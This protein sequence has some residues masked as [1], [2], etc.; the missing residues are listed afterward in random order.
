MG[1]CED[2]WI[3]CVCGLSLVD[4]VMEDRENYLKS[5]IWYSVIWCVCI[6]G[7]V[8]FLVFESIDI[9]LVE[10]SVSRCKDV[11]GVW[12]VFNEFIILLVY[13]IFGLEMRFEDGWEVVKF[14]FCMSFRCDFYEYSSLGIYF[15]FFNVL[16]NCFCVFVLFFIM[17][18]CCRNLLL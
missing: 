18:K 6:V 5:C 11:Y 4:E 14:G 10:V 7:V 1:C 13:F 16:M 12:E 8:D 9:S 15:L 3:S 2:G 17:L